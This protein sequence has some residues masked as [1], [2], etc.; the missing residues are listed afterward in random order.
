MTDARSRLAI[1]QGLPG[2]GKTTRARAWVAEKPEHRVRVN[3]DDFRT[4][5]H[6]GRL[7]TSEQ[8]R[9][10]TIAS[11]AAILALLRAG[12]DVV[13]DD[14]NLD[15]ARLPALLEVAA[16]AGATVERWDMTGVPV[17]ECLRRNRRR[18]GPARVPD[19]VITSMNAD[20]IQPSTEGAPA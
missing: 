20:F 8:E 14:T 7:G 15:P 4:M 19:V 6:A 9:Q 13:C 10:V 16:Q 3:R 11:H 17:A 1:T 5:T 18:H 2:S 12:Y